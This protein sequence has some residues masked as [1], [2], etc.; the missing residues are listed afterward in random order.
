MQQTLNQTLEPKSWYALARC[1]GIF[2]YYFRT[3]GTIVLWVLAVILGSGLL[4][5]LLPLI[6][7]SAEYGG[8]GGISA[9][10]ATTMLVALICSCIVAGRGTRFLLR[11][12]T[13]RFSVWLCNL[14]S[15][16]AATVALLLGSLVVSVLLSYLALPLTENATSYTQGIIPQR[17]PYTAEYLS[18]T[19]SASIQ[20]LP[21]QLLWVAEYVSL[22]YLLGCC[23]RR[24]KG[25]TLTVV[26]G[27]PL[28][29]MMLMIIPAVEQTV[30]IAMQ[31]DQSELMAMG[32]QWMQ[33]LSNVLQFVKEQ[34]PIIQLI[35]AVVSLPLSYLC[36]RGTK[37]P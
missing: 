27:L 33:W 24:A 4:S 7:P 29:F 17:V 5:L 14:L 18:S 10:V 8:R 20:M 12:G 11:F 9:D 16:L 37:Q 35:A 3:L 13:P 19:L 32:L 6:F 22:F 21:T 1:K 25:W 30:S 23:L 31:A 15:I 36:M 28:A 34:W 2:R 26:I